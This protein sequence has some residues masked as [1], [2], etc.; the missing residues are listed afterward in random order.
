MTAMAL[1][2]TDWCLGHFDKDSLPSDFVFVP[3]NQ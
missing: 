3:L 2:R 1:I